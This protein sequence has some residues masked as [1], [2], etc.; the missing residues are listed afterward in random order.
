MFDEL[1][2]FL[3]VAETKSFTGAARRLNF[4]QPAISQQIRKLESFFRATL[5]TRSVSGRQVELTGEGELVRQAGQDIVGRLEELDQD[6]RRLW[7]EEG[8]SL[9]VGASMTIGTQLLPRLLQPFREKYPQFVPRLLI[10]NT[11]EVCE[12]L[13]A[14]EVDVGL[15]EGRNMYHDFQR[16]DFYTD[17]LVLVA[18]PAVAGAFSAF[19][20]SRLGKA[21]WVVR[22][23]GSG[24]AQYLQAFLESNHIIIENRIQ[25]NSN[26][27]ICALVVEGLGIAFLSRLAVERELRA[28][29]LVQLPIDRGYTRK[30]SCVT[31]K[32]V[33][34]SLAVSSFQSIL[35]RAEDLFPVPCGPLE[36]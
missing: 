1:R 10:G 15:I 8:D 24:T 18:A 7:E 13:Q 4:S 35:N 12:A 5:L 11:W 2:V 19:S 26:E 9:R 33:P 22:E 25:C 30:F 28:G 16:V 32:D 14:G 6:L 27:A 34:L 3:T 20:P 36:R 17:P 21:T 31:R 23:P 29:T